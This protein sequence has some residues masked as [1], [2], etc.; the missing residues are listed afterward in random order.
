MIEWLCQWP[1]CQ[2]SWAVRRHFLTRMQALSGPDSFAKSLGPMITTNLA[3]LRSIIANALPD[4]VSTGTAP[5]SSFDQQR[6]FQNSCPPLDA[7]PIRVLRE[8]PTLLRCSFPP[9]PP[10]SVLDTMHSLICASFAAYVTTLQVGRGSRCS[11]NGE[12]SHDSL[13]LCCYKR[14]VQS[15]SS[16]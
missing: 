11:R 4:D 10:D 16:A 1:P 3:L 14:M 15:W 12:T 13:Y 6:S 2:R 7:V 8:T 9:I 5:P